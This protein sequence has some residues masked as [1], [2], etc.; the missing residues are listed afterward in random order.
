MRSFGACLLKILMHPLMA[1]CYLLFTPLSFSQ[2]LSDTLS[3]RLGPGVG[4]PVNIEL[5]SG[6]TIDI[7]QRRNDWLLVHDPRGEGGWATIDQVDVAGGLAERQAWRLTELKEE[8][9]GVLIGR[10]YQLESNYGASLGWKMP[11]QY[12]EWSF[13]HEKSSD[14]LE[15]WQ[16]ISSWYGISEPFVWKSY[17]GLGLGLGYSWENSHSHVFSSE[18]EEGESLY[19]GLELALGYRPANTIDTGISVRYLRDA[20]S[21]GESASVISL[22]WSFGI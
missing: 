20:S 19:A 15:N 14:S 17:Y 11:K 9:Y 21:Q 16:S 5:P 12:E 22:F 7:K 10:F 6:S 1:I 13:E 3:L 18:G 8:D 2:E 4:Y